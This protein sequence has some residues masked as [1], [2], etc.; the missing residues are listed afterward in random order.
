MVAAPPRPAVASS[1]PVPTPSRSQARRLRPS[2]LLLPAAVVLWVVAVHGTRPDAM[3]DWGLLTALPVAFYVAL[4]AL[5]I[6]IGLVLTDARI[7]PLRLGLH[8]VALV[9]V[10]HGTVPA[11]FPETNFPWAY[12]HM[13]VV[14]YINRRGGLDPS[15]DIYQNWPGFFAAAAFFGRVAGVGSPL[16][17][18]K[19]APVYFNLLICLELGFV[20][21]R[22][23]VGR[24]E[25]WLALFLVVVGNWVGQDYFAP[26]ALGLVLSLATFGMV[27]AWF[28]VDRPSAAVRM[29][30]RVARR[31]V[32]AP[33]GRAAVPV[34]V[35]VTVLTGWRRALALA[36]I[37][38]VFAVVV[39]SH[40]LSPYL[41][42]SGLAL[43]TLGG[44]VRPRW[45][46][47]GLT[48][49][50]IG[51]L[52]PHL[53][54]LH[55]TGNLSGSPLNPR[56]VLSALGNP[57][58]N[59][60]SSGFGGGT[61]RP[62]RALTAL[63]APALILA[64]WGLGLIGAF[65]RLRAGRPVR[66]MLLLAVAPALLAF[67]QNYGGEAIFRIYL[68]SLPWIAVLAASALAPRAVRWGRLSGAAVVVV[69]TGAAVLFMAAFYGSV[70]LY[71][72]RPGAVAA[73]V[74]FYGHAQPG[75]VLGVGAPDSPARLAGNYDDFLRGST[76]PPLTSLDAFRGRRLGVGDLPALADLYRG[77]A[78]G[79]PGDVFLVLTADQD[80]YAHVLGLLPKGSIAGLDRALAA[81][82]DWRVFYRNRDAVIYQFV[83]VAPLAAPRTALPAQEPL[84]DCGGGNCGAG[85]SGDGGKGVVDGHPGE[86]GPTPAPADRAPAS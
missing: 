25:R 56:D 46:V 77:S 45:M 32:R 28:Q 35:P 7:S 34:P 18:A 42:V 31:L 16:A 81:S 71:R 65:R 21:R 6:S 38:V 37:F 54:Y 17:Y 30:A 1:P 36:G 43:L 27:L 39:V 8:L 73:A 60:K 19:W 80:V 58:D 75:S 4:G 26:Q 44:V 11:L 5:L 10:L 59:L 57:F 83:G 84:Q 78:V 29:A 14:D 51:Y 9:V 69:L 40:Q 50:M 47:A 53:P 20:L 12:K 63:G 62:G 61:P 64:M 72:V 55:R 33:A 67:G 13:G 74:Y 52:V 66:A 86:L 41:V 24:R 76:P 68:F 15:V 85:G 79:T 48:A 22:L 3:D 70:E 23:A 2:D 49:V 82:P